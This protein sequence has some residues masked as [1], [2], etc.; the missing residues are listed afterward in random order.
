M[1]KRDTGL[2][3]N[4]AEVPLDQQMSVSTGKALP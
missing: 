2:I 3:M 4:E 1:D